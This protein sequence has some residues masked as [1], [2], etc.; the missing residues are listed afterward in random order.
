MPALPA[1]NGGTGLERLRE[2]LAALYGSRARL[3]L[4]SGA[5]GG[6]TA[7]L[8]VPQDGEN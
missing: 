4:E 3:T 2:R 7:T 6:C 1:A 8:T 5:D